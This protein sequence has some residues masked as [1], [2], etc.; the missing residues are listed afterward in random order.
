MKVMN[1]IK[2]DFKRSCKSAIISFMLTH[3]QQQ[4]LNLPKY[5]IIFM[6]EI[7]SPILLLSL[8]HIEHI[9]SEASEAQ[10]PEPE[11]NILLTTI[12]E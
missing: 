10:E 1:E 5:E 4:H 3:F 9:I 6:A 2:S 7:T 11:N 8:N 12:K